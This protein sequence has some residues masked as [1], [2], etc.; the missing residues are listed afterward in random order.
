MDL[1]LH[2]VERPEMEKECAC[3]IVIKLPIPTDCLPECAELLEIA[4]GTQQLIGSV[5]V[6]LREN[7][8]ASSGL[9]VPA[10][11]SCFLIEALE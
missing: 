4:I 9:P 10:R 5:P 11:T 6:V 3:H 8:G 7:H 2:S 1:P